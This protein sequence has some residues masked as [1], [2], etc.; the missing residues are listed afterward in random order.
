[1]TQGFNQKLSTL[2]TVY[3]CWHPDTFALPQARIIPYFFPFDSHPSLPVGALFPTPA[4]HHGLQKSQTQLK[5]PQSSLGFW[6]VPNVLG[7]SGGFRGW[8]LLFLRFFPTLQIQRMEF[9]PVQAR[10]G[11]NGCSGF[12]FLFF[13]MLETAHFSC[14]CKGLENTKRQLRRPSTPAACALASF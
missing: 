8:A 12:F 4:P 3:H 14:W 1:M 11:W 2:I 10:V 7:T 13:F 5:S 9:V 6:G